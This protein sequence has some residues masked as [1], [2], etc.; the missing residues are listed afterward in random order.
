VPPEVGPVVGLF[1]ETGSGPMEAPLFHAVTLERD[2]TEALS[3]RG[4]STAGASTLP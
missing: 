4:M 3:E 1:L 2:A